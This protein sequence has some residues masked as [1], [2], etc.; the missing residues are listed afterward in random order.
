[1]VPKGDNFTPAKHNNLL[2]FLHFMGERAKAMYCL[3]PKKLTAN[4]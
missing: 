2:L 3:Y 1:V 4:E